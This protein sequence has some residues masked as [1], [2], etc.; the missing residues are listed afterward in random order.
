MK[1]EV[2]HLNRLANREFDNETREARSRQ[3][4]A[5]F[6]LEDYLSRVNNEGEEARDRLPQLD[7]I[8][9]QRTLTQEETDQ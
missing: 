7:Q 2:I 6:V 4:L 5:A 8:I 1:E 9:A 3:A